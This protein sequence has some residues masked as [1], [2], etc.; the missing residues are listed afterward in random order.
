MKRNWRLAVI[1]CFLVM[2]FAAI[3]Y[4]LVQL[5]IVDRSF[6]LKEGDARIL[7]NVKINA[8]R[9][10]ITDRNNQ[11]LAISTPVVSY[12][13]DPR[14]FH[15]TREE[16]HQLANA[17]S[18][19]SSYIEKRIRRSQGRGFFYLKRRLPPATS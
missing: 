16:I 7:R 3:G 9:G 14:L 19:T 18:L 13:F 10:M 2:V 15:P 12:W 6:L 5:S 1:I 11:P 17:L 8:S 4:R